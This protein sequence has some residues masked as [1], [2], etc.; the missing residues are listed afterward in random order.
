MPH[1]P[2][3][4]DRNVANRER[5]VAFLVVNNTNTVNPT[6]FTLR[7]RNHTVETAQTPWR[8]S[9]V[10]ADTIVV[11]ASLSRLL[12]FVHV[13]K[14][15]AVI[16]VRK[17]R[18]CGLTS[19]GFHDV[20]VDTAQVLID[21]HLVVG[22]VTVVGDVQLLQVEKVRNRDGRQLT[23]HRL[24]AEC[25]RELC[26][27]KTLDTLAMVTFE[28]INLSVRA[29]CPKRTEQACCL[30]ESFLRQEHLVWITDE[31]VRPV[32]HVQQVSQHHNAVGVGFTHQLQCTANRLQVVEGNEC[33]VV[34][35]PITNVG[36]GPEERRLE[37]RLRSPRLPTLAHLHVD[38]GDGRNDRLNSHT[39]SEPN[40]QLVQ[41]GNDNLIVYL[42]TNLPHILN[43]VVNLPHVVVVVHIF[44]LGR[45]ARLH[46][47]G[48]GVTRY[49]EQFLL[50]CLLLLL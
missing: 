5:L 41:R 13:S 36:I 20:T 10:E 6:L 49:L 12:I 39:P 3:T 1:S 46:G 21:P 18:C 27:D 29:E 28:V 25:D 47:C 34:I 45:C 8:I 7:S 24:Q 40:L 44:Q 2:T 22:V 19:V 30:L 32:A 17:Y 38:R 15:H 26:F 33:A 37:L 23:V 42:C 16:A 11:M 50:H 35:S 31:L 48:S 4:K 14:N 43:V 9:R